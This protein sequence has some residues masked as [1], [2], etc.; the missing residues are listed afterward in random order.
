MLVLKKY[1]KIL[2]FFAS[3]VALQGLNSC[4]S[5]DYNKNN[6]LEDQ[7]VDATF[8]IVPVEGETN[9]YLLKAQTQ[10]VIAY[11]RWVLSG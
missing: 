4:D 8:S 11:W 9:S 1:K 7:K 2:L 5:E 10:N 3:I 6:G